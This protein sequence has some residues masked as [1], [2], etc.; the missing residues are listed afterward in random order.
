MA[1]SVIVDAG[2]IVALLSRRDTH[3]N[4]ARQ[5]AARFPPPWRTCDAVVSEA[6]HLL[7]PG[8]AS[9]LGALLRR[10]S[11]T[12]AFDLARELE[13]VLRLLEKYAD[14]PMSLADACLV[15]MSEVEGEPMVLTTDSDFKIY[16]R[17]SRRVVPCAM[18]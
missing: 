15:R 18:P 14:V 2:F 4:W 5:T 10:R 7:G 6:V 17:H 3:H 1:A 12:L 16:R 13:P 8:R 9:P 11:L